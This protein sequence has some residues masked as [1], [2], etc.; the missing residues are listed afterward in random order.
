MYL[1]SDLLDSTDL[2]LD[3]RLERIL[4]AVATLACSLCRTRR[5]GQLGELFARSEVLP[6]HPVVVLRR[7]ADACHRRRRRTGLIFLSGAVGVDVSLQ[8][9]QLHA[10]DRGP[11]DERFD[12]SELI[13]RHLGQEPPKSGLL[14][15]DAL[16]S[17]HLSLRRHKITAVSTPKFAANVKESQRGSHVRDPRVK[18]REI[19]RASCR[20][21]GKRAVLAD[22][23]KKKK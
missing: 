8:I 21:R 6:H 22:R 16:L 15:L 11:L 14:S 7:R 5:L 9:L 2:R 13:F 10:Q 17:R 3:E 20:E 19:G 12:E 1:G 23:L 4:L 18:R